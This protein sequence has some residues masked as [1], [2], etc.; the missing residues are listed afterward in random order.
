MS[1]SCFA[2]QTTTWDGTPAI[3]TLKPGP[4]TAHADTH[5]CIKAKGVLA[6]AQSSKSCSPIPTEDYDKPDIQALLRGF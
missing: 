5:S 2:G 6:M 1:A 4:G 3:F